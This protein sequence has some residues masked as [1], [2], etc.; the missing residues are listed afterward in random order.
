MAAILQPSDL[1]SK[2]TTL[3]RNGFIHNLPSIL[4]NTCY[5]HEFYIII[6]LE[7]YYSRNFH[8]QI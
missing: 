4:K 3:H 5:P 8:A 7:Y 2:S 6:R 1:H